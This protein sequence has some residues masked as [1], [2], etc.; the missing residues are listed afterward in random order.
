ME[1]Q[2]Q[3]LWSDCLKLNSGFGG[4]M[5]QGKPG[6]L[7]LQ[8]GGHLPQQRAQSPGSET[9]VCCRRGCSERW[10]LTGTI[11]GTAGG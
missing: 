2:S 11:S 6:G 3:L 8:C 9:P 1:T 10:H 7:A 5:W 4:Y